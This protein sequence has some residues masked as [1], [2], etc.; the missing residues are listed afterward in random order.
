LTHYTKWVHRV[1]VIIP[2]S[3]ESA[4]NS[5]GTNVTDNELMNAFVNGSIFSAWDKQLQ[6]LLAIGPMLLA[7][8]CALTNSEFQ[9]M[10][11]PASWVSVKTMRRVRKGSLRGLDAEINFVK[12]LP[13]AAVRFD[14]TFN[15][16]L[17]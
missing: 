15:A 8:A 17:R 6:Q 9:K 12:P 4:N 3:G 13:E 2:K 11:R 14:L 16:Q 5:S 1:K 7:A 10:G